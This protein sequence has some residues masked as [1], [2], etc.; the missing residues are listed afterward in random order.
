MKIAPCY[1][2]YGHAMRHYGN[3]EFSYLLWHNSG[4]AD[5]QSALG[6]PQTTGT[7]IS[8]RCCHRF[9]RFRHGNSSNFSILNP[10]ATLSTLQSRT[11]PSSPKRRVGKNECIDHEGRI[12]V[13]LVKV[14]MVRRLLYSTLLF[15]SR[16]MV[17]SS[18][19]QLW[20]AI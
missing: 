17:M 11:M 15:S 18:C 20:Q 6:M 2:C 13:F 16:L 1:D 5:E 10:F 9:L 14:G 4:F 8:M 12:R 7:P 19:M 3:Y